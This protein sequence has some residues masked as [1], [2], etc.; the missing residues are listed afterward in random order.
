MKI[1]KIRLFFEDLKT[2]L[3]LLNPPTVIA[4]SEPSGK[5]SIYHKYYISERNG[6]KPVLALITIDYN[7]G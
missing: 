6:G 3:A 7:S 2:L 5:K 4:L 1:S